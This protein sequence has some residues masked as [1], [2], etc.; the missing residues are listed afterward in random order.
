MPRAATSE[1]QR[2]TTAPE[3]KRTGSKEKKK[4]DE[5]MT[6][7]DDGEM[8]GLELGTMVWESFEADLKEWDITPA[9]DGGGSSM[10]PASTS[11]SPT[12]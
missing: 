7:P 10:K 12:S 9:E 1:A 3:K 11:S 2:A 5:A 4:V 6:M 8:G